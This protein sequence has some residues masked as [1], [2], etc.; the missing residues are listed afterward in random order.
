MHRYLASGNS[1]ISLA[2]NFRVSPQS[3]SVIVREV[4]TSICKFLGPLYLKRPTTSDWENNEQ[5]FRTR[6]NYP[7]AIGAID[8]KHVKIR[9]P[10]FAGS[11]YYNY[12]HF[13][14]IVLLGVVDPFY[15]FTLV[16]IG[17]SGS[18]SDGGVLSRSA[19]GKASDDGSIGFPPP[20]NVGNKILPHVILCDDAFSLKQNMMKPYPG[21]F[22]PVERRIFNYRLSRGRMVVENAFGVLAARWRI[23]HTAIT[24]DLDLTRLI[25]QTCVIL[26]NYLISKQDMCNITMDGPNGERGNWRDSVENDSGLQNIQRQ[27]TNNYTVS[28]SEVR[29][30]FC[31]YFNNDG[32]VSWQNDR[33]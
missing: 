30:E 7:N 9:A 1:Q 29:K 21:S 20:R 13:H 19:M 14:S 26:H 23:C 11:T 25:I 33:I 2:F 5:G 8:G 6:W 24:A 10:K 3:V 28:A 22:L 16:D 32:A 15:K 27:G 12:K 4:M 31:N 17:A 18:Q